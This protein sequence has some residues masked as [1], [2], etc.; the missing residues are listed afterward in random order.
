MLHFPKPGSAHG[1]SIVVGNHVQYG[2]RI[3]CNWLNIAMSSAIKP[4]QYLRLTA[5][6]RLKLIADVWESLTESGETLPLSDG[7]A[8]EAERRLA[9]LK[10]DRSTGMTLEEFRKKR[11][12]KA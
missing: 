10:S 1:H 6:E 9:E 2:D 12:W 3:A 8:E 5:S 11:G 4:S 7:N